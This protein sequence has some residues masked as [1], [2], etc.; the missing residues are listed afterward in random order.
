M[1]NKKSKRP[2]RMNDT[3]QRQC[4]REFNIVKRT[5]SLQRFAKKSF[6][7]EISC[8]Q[9]RS[10]I[11]INNNLQRYLHLGID[12]ENTYCCMVPSQQCNV[13][14]LF[15]WNISAGEFCSTCVKLAQMMLNTITWLSTCRCR[16]CK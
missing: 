1:I 3:D 5:S 8:D 7:K 11:W 14:R 13:G 4:A 9:Q 15:C 12:S 10:M 2:V 6:R 16:R